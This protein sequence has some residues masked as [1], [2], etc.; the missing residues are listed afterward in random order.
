M[1]KRARALDGGTMKEKDCCCTML[2]IIVPTYNESGNIRQ[3]AKDIF[4]A[5]RSH[6]V[7]GELIIVD[8]NSP[9]GTGRMAE[10]LKTFYAVQVIH[11]AGKLGLATAVVEGF[12]AARYPILCVMD[13][14][15]SHPASVLPDMLAVIHSG[16]ADLVIGSRFVSGGGMEK[17][18]WYRRFV[19]WVAR[20]LARPLTAVMDNTSGFLMFRR[21]VIEGVPLNPLGFKIGLEIIVKGRYERVREWP[22][23]FTDRL[24]GKSNLGGKQIGEYLLQLGQLHWYRWTQAPRT[25]RARAAE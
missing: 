9:D 2:S 20:S 10:D 12:A 4:T 21:E 19:S 5:L 11:R 3:L 1:F 15:L 8:D 14:D 22:I 18:P 23:L 24:A 25:G 16:E 13:A 7:E 17:W 6:G